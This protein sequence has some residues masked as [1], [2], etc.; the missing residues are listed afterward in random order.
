MSGRERSQTTILASYGLA[1]WEEVQL[2][3]FINWANSYILTKGED[4]I[5]KDPKEDFADGL[6]L[7]ALTEVLTGESLGRHH[8]NP[9]MLMQKM[10]NLNLV[11]KMVNDFVASK[12]IRIQYSA[13]QI[14]EGD[15]KSLMGMLWIFISKFAI[16]QIA[17]GDLTAKEGLLIWCQKKLKD[18]DNIKIENLSSS[19]KDGMAFCALIH[20][21]R[22]DLIDYKS[23]NP[24]NKYE[25][26]KLAF[27]TA[28]TELGVPALLDAKDLTDPAVRLDEKSVMT[29]LSFLWKIFKDAKNDEISGRRI[30]KLIETQRTNNALTKSYEDGAES[31]KKWI[32]SKTTFFLSAK[33][34]N[35]ESDVNN[36]GIELQD[37]RVGLKLTKLAEK[38]DLESSLN[39][40]NSKL[41]NENR[42]IFSCPEYLSI[43]KVNSQWDALS[44]AEYGYEDALTSARSELRRQEITLQG[45]CNQAK[46]EQENFEGRM[47][48]A[49]KER[50]E[51]NDMLQETIEGIDSISKADAQLQ[52]QQLSEK[53]HTK[54]STKVKKLGVEIQTIKNSG[55]RVPAFLS[56]AEVCINEINGTFE[57]LG[58]LLASRRGALEAELLNQKALDAKRA[59]FSQRVEEFAQWV[60]DQSDTL[61]RNIL[62]NSVSDVDTLTEECEFLSLEIESKSDEIEDIAGI[63][64]CNGTSDDSPPNP[65]A[66]YI[67]PDLEDMVDELRLLVEMRRNNLEE[68][69]NRQTEN[70]EK[71]KAYIAALDIYERWVMGIKDECSVAI[72]ADISHQEKLEAA[73]EF[74]ERVQSEGSENLA[75]VNEAQ[76]SLSEASL[77]IRDTGSKKNL[78]N[79]RV[80]YDLVL[81]LVN[82]AKETAKSAIAKE[83]ETGITEEMYSE[84][85]EMFETF[86]KSNDGIL[87]DNELQQVLKSMD[88]EL[89]QEE[90]TTLVGG[91][92]VGFDTFMAFMTE[93]LK[94]TDTYDQVIDSFDMV[95]NNN[96]EKKIKLSQLEAVLSAED[97]EYIKDNCDI[98]NDS[99]DYQTYTGM[100]FGTITSKEIEEQRERAMAEEAEREAAK[101]A[102]EAEARREA[103]ERRQ[104]EEAEEARR[105]KEE[106][107]RK[108]AAEEEARVQA[109]QAAAAAEEA[110]RV[111]DEAKRKAEEEER[112]RKEEDARR[113][114]AEDEEKRKREEAERLKKA[115]EE[116][117][118]AAIKAAKDAEEAMK[119]AGK[120][121]Y[122]LK[123]GGTKGKTFSRRNWQK[124]YFTIRG[125]GM[126]KYYEDASTFDSGSEPKGSFMITCAQAIR[127]CTY[128]DR[129][130][131]IAFESDSGRRDETFLMQAMSFGEAEEW[132]DL[133]KLYKK[134]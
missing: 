37:Y 103:E 62:T 35:E 53:A 120:E 109:A 77:S 52:Q 98:V 117:R 22:P 16:D 1:R 113:Q 79:M 23:L 100:C 102:A 127:V 126:L 13:E 55:V 70:E 48:W 123:K 50:S 17:E 90:L 78:A 84:L 56:N 131:C 116:A 94:D 104:K 15:L 81:R 119:V 2:K 130:N 39:Y 95:S 66:R 101:A 108:A 128:K 58:G 38:G 8:K 59:Q 9:K 118:I 125:D 14:L 64:E 40:I 27:D 114:A 28:A 20:K 11:T 6:K 105:K 85:K 65:Y 110:K 34:G 122:L 96:S 88:M 32:D 57:K 112:K 76:E 54:Q 12:G 7:I 87:Q 5:V 21:N 124:R 99:L 75:L 63:T 83:N 46:L 44:T 19:W 43:S 10:E 4:F 80:E 86:D 26:M 68:E 61:Q 49:G 3:T 132:V 29:Y 30:T 69:R 82:D 24:S 42:P 60:D 71:K 115:E 47:N 41:E 31:L 36:C 45:L 73:T 92:G 25:N 134:E 121:G 129:A 72:P 33:F 106:E 111:A 93:K 133:L 91:N 18:Y 74:E 97:V 51:I 67:I 107:D 89:S